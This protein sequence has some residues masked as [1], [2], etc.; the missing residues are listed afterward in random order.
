MLSFFLVPLTISRPKIGVTILVSLIPL[1][2]FLQAAVIYAYD[3]PGVLG[4]N[5]ADL[6]NWSNVSYLLHSGLINYISSYAVGLFVGYLIANQVTVK[7]EFKQW[8]LLLLLT[9][10]FLLAF[11]MPM[12]FDRTVRWQDIVLGSTLRTAISMSFAG[13]IY[14]GWID[15]CTRLAA[16]F[17]SARIFQVM[18]KLSYSTFMV[19]ICVIWYENMNMRHAMDYSSLALVSSLLGN[20][21]KTN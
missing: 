12:M 9:V 20:S 5:T 10:L 19:H 15:N 8:L 16:N 7:S 13:L 11:A 4:A 6:M 17:L 18:G 2:I 1:G 3:I 21:V 14:M